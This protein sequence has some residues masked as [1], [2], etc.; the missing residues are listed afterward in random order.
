[1]LIYI[2]ILW[3]VLFHNVEAKPASQ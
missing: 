2:V 3:I 1:M